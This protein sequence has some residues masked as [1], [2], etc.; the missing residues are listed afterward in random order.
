MTTN[1]RLG[2]GTRCFVST[3]TPAAQTVAA[4]NAAATFAHASNAGR[5]MEVGDPLTATISTGQ[6]RAVSTSEPM[7]RDVVLK[8]IVD[9]SNP[10]VLTL[11]FHKRDSNAGQM[12]L[13]TGYAAR[14]PIVVKLQNE[15]EA[16]GA[17]HQEEDQASYFRGL[18][19]GLNPY[20]AG[21]GGDFLNIEVVLELV[22]APL[23][24]TA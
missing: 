20:N 6:A 19:S 16:G 14:T 1:V 2:H 13:R 12:A 10:G 5:Y 8:Q 21:A 24:N 4:Y 3:A 15:A 11:T 18:V 17:D 22:V 23:S 7:D 9:I